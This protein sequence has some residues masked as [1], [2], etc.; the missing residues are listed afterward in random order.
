MGNHAFL[1][2][3]GASRWLA[4]PPSARLEAT[5]PSYTNEAA[6]EGT[7][8][9]R[10]C[11]LYLLNQLKQIKA[12]D[13]NRELKIVKNNKHYNTEMN[14]H[15]M[16]YVQFVLDKFHAHSDAMIF[17]EDRISL[18]DYVPESFGTS[19]NIIIADYIL[20]MTDLKYGKGV[21]VEAEKNDQLRLYALGALKKYSLL[22]RIDKVSMTIYQPRL[23]NFSTC[24]IDAKEL[25][26]WGESFVKPT[27]Q[28]AFDGLG[29]YKPGSHCRFC[30]ARNDCKTLANHHMKMAEFAFEDPNK[31]SDKDI[32]EILTKAADF[33]VWLSGIT[34]YALAEAV[35][36]QKK[37]PGFKLVAGR[38]NRVYAN[39]EEIICILK[40]NKIK[41][42]L[43]MT[44]P[45]LVGIT[46][47]EKNIGKADV[48][49]ICGSYIVKPPG[50]AT[51]VPEWDKRVEL[52]STEAAKI[53]F[54]NIEPEN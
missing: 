8:A 4:C 33:K 53:A 49:K 42:T 20:D 25:V 21:R 37:W 46:T 44:E 23:D 17:I 27:A 2:P 30:K 45:A 15:A 35:N 12:I 7:L 39:P 9:H 5:Y 24:V 16:D 22:Y 52:N 43:F 13:F 28:Q 14:D 34:T 11:E 36:N 6:D 51:L 19:D 47:L 31:L 54:E 38:S 50:A 41:P 40:K 3:S 32:A 18:G 10:L 48:E 26:E 1:S 29:E